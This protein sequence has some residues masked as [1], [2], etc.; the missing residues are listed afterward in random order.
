[1][2]MA[3]KPKPDWSPS[4]QDKYVD[5]LEHELIRERQRTLAIRVVRVVDSRTGVVMTIVR[6]EHTPDGNLII[7]VK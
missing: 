4:P 5:Q 3:E 7:E 6:V 2:S 1:M